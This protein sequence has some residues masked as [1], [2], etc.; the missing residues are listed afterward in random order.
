MNRETFYFIHELS[1]NRFIEA[2][3]EL[4]GEGLISTIVIHS[5]KLLEVENTGY[6]RVIM[7]GHDSAES[8][9]SRKA[10]PEP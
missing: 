1:R 3:Q 2:L 10:C 4:T 7:S 8:I 9:L 6:T 5:V